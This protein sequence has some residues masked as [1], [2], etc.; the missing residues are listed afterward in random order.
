[1]TARAIKTTMKSV[2]VGTE[3]VGFVYNRGKLGVEA[4]DREQRSLGL[5]KTEPEASWP[6][7]DEAKHGAESFA[8]MAMPLEAVD[9]KLAARIKRNNET[10]HPMGLAP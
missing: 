10:P 3:C 6:T 4:L 5:F 2:C 9:P 8:L 1:M 7:L